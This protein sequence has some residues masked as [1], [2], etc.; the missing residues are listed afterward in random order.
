MLLT[1]PL[2]FVSKFLI[3]FSFSFFLFANAIANEPVD[4][5]KKKEKEK[6]KEE[7]N[8]KSTPD[9]KS[10]IDY[11]K[12]QK[13]LAEIKID[14]KENNTKSEVELFGLYDPAKSDLSL[15]MWTNTDGTLVKNAFKRIEKIKL[16]KFSE[17]IF[18]DTIFTYSYGPNKNLS[19]EEFLKLKLNWLIKNNKIEL[20]EDF[21][22]T[23]L[24]FSNKS[25]L[26]KYLVDYYIASAN[27]EGGC[28]KFLILAKK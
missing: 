7:I 5:W 14:D 3:F 9:E 6:E 8:I 28:E 4:I 12:K 25:K 11:S 22:S 24:N 18:T 15:N 21:L 20:I 1:K 26:I 10:Q 23:N 2:N 16:S 19:D 27:L 13:N 17:K